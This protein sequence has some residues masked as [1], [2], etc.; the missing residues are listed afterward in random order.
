MP[1]A[2]VTPEQFTM[3][4]FDA[5]A[6]ATIAE[7]VAGVVG[8]DDDFAFTVEV[9]ETT[10]LTPA[11]VVSVEPP[12]LSVESG[13]LEEPKVPRGMSE[14]RTADTVGRLLFELSDRMDPDFGA[15]SVDDDVDPPRQTAWDCWSVGRLGRLGEDVQKQRWLY[16]FRNR[17]GFTDEADRAFHELWSAERLTW[18]EIEKL[19][20]AAEQVNPAA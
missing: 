20:L 6:I 4:E 19:S 12:V 2:T 14:E 10:P 9:D 18:S 16:H 11:D 5:D 8:F 13:A 17:H 3:V 7:R 1:K 15:P